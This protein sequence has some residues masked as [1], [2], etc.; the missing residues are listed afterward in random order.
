VRV[1][2]AGCAEAFWLGFTPGDCANPLAH[3][4][5]HARTSALARIIY[6][7]SR[8]A[9]SMLGFS[10]KLCTFPL[11]ATIIPALCAESLPEVPGTYRHRE[12]P[13]CLP[14]Y[15]L[16]RII[17][18]VGMLVLAPYFA[19]RGWRRGEHSGALRERLGIL[20]TGFAADPSSAAVGKAG[21]AL[22]GGAI[23]IHAVSVGEV[24]AA[25]P[26]VEGLNR[27][28]PGRLIFVST[29]TETG[30]RLARERLQSAN[31]IFYFPLDWVV[32]VRRA[33]A[34]DSTGARDCDGN[35]DLAQFFAGSPPLRYSGD[36]RERAHLRKVLLPLRTME[37]SAW[38][39][40][41][42]YSSGCGVVFG[43]E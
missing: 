17:T 41:R 35:G 18:A 2:G 8:L 39:I 32:P 15:F 23:W 9:T 21:D 20:P 10:G 22:G 34:H 33:L 29:T 31:E 7:L 30:Q 19:L 13:Q 40:F 3:I 25:K 26:L 43:A 16:Y 36:F 4:T 24:L 5:K 27:E 42:T 28:F 1:E 12:S 14:M 38:G 37:I 11:A 6:G